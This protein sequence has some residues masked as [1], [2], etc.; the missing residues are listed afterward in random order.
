MEETKNEILKALQKIHVENNMPETIKIK[1]SEIID[2][3][4]IHFDITMTPE[5]CK[6]WSYIFTGDEQLEYTEF[7]KDF[8]YNQE[9][10][11][12]HLVYKYPNAFI[13]HNDEWS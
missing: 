2:N 11:I 13:I 10:E 12:L 8:N 6:D 3:S 9:L 4:A 5:E 1:L 7:S